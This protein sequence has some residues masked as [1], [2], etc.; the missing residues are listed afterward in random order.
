MHERLSEEFSAIGFYLSGHPLDAYDKVLKRIGHVLQA[1]C[2]R[3]DLAARFGGDE[4]ALVFDEA[5]IEDAK[6]VCERI[7]N[8]IE[9]H[10]DD[11]A[12]RVTVSIGLAEASDDDT[13]ESLLRRADAALY[14]AKAEGRNR[15]AADA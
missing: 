10:A 9:R 6:I 13:V 4:F 12:P 2:R 8:V 11:G 15:V 14:R 1:A 3:T 7:R 5:S